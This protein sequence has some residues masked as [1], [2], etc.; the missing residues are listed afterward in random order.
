MMFRRI[1]IVLGAGVLAS[2][3]GKSSDDDSAEDF[4]TTF[5][6]FMTTGNTSVSSVIMSISGESDIALIEGQTGTSQNP[7]LGFIAGRVM[8]G[9]GSPIAD[10]TIQATNDSGLPAGSIFYQSGISF[11]YSP[12]LTMTSSTGR[13]VVQN[14]QAG[15][16]N[17]R[18]SAGA[19]G[20][21]YVQIAGGTTVF[22]QLTATATGTQ[23]DWNGIT[24]NLLASGRSV[25]GSAEPSVNYQV[26]G[27]GGPPGP[28]SNGTTGA[29]DLGTVPAR[30]MF[31]VKCTKTGFVDTYTYVQAA[32]ADL[33]PGLGGG[34][35]FITSTAN[36]DSE[37]NATGVTLTAGTGIVTGRVM[38]GAGGFT[39]EARDG[40]D[41]AVGQVLYGDNTD[42]GRPNVLLTSTMTDGIFYIY[43]VPPGQIFLRATKTGL[44]VSTYVDSF[45]DGITLTVDLLPLAQTQ[46]TITISGALSSLQGFAVPK[47]RIILHGLGIGDETDA[48]GEYSIQNVPARHVFIVRTSK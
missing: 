38:D 33:T 23:P 35:L 7:A 4:R 22:A 12:G 39:V 11:A 2:C 48:F 9:T 16:V 13:F 43:N 46:A 36:R 10:V 31:L 41:Q 27:F 30:N 14:V 25:P 1:A 18:C 24:V 32:N 21:L 37:I 42:G 8:D 29:F 34:N 44:A 17:I 45:A 19:D 26:L 20:N 5:G 3:G 6:Y 40:N 28:S 15:R 47:G